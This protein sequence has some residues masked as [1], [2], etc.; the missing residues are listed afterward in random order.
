MQ[1][2][3]KSSATYTGLSGNAKLLEMVD[4]FLLTVSDGITRLAEKISKDV[5][6][7][8]KRQKLKN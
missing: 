4:I 1:A 3:H 8:Q 6:F 7:N 2:S 5:M